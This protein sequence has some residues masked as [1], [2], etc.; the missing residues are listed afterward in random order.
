VSANK[1]IVVESL[2]IDPFDSNHWLY[3]TGLTIYGGHNLQSWPAVHV[4]SL[5]DAVE[6]TAVQ[7]LITPPGIGVQLIS[8]VADVG[9]FVVSSITVFPKAA[10]SCHSGANNSEVGCHMALRLSCSLL[11]YFSLY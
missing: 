5:A 8:A 7:G 4:S 10:D 6:E 2:E 11:I 9:S 3:G 1:I